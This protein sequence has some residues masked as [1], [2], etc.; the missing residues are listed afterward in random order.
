MADMR[1]LVPGEKRTGSGRD[2]ALPKVP[3]QGSA[4]SAYERPLAYQGGVPD[5]GRDAR[6]CPEELDNTRSMKEPGSGT[7]GDGQTARKP[8]SYE[9]ITRN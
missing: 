8:K 4:G 3:Q 9:G 6:L 7:S 5:K 1:K 2:G